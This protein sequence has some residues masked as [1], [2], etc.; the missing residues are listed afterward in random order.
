MAQTYTTV[1]SFNSAVEKF[2]VD[3]SF[4]Y[5]DS[6]TIINELGEVTEYDD[7][8]NSIDRMDS[9]DICQQ[10]VI[11]YYRAIE[12]LS[13]NDPS[14]KESLEL[15]SDLCYETGSLNS[16][17]LAS[18]LKT[19]YAE[20]EFFEFCKDL[21]SEFD[22]A[23]VLDIDESETEL[24]KLAQ[25]SIDYDRDWFSAVVDQ[26]YNSIT[27]YLNHDGLEPSKLPFDEESLN[28]DLTYEE[29]NLSDIIELV[30]SF[31]LIIQE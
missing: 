7:L 26:S 20:E 21:R 22:D 13:E 29:Y 8:D 11:Y 17:L 1:A 3:Y 19:S 9:G 31:T 30:E 25:Y 15:A 27:V 16:E 4:D 10:E 2:I 28:D 24:V 12:F 14:L 6:S 18:I 23:E 5:L